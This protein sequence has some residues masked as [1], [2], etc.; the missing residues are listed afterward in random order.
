MG[1]RLVD[2]TGERFGKVTVI[3]R[4]SEYAETPVKW[5]CICECGKE[6]V[7]TSGRL[8][9][10]ATKSCGCSRYEFIS[11]A[12]RIH[13]M[14]K[15]RIHRTWS[16]MIERCTCKTHKQ[17]M[18]YGGRGITVCKDWLDFITFYNWAME[19]GYEHNLT[20]DRI[21]VN[22]NYEPSN[23]RWTDS[24]T[25][26]NNTRKTIKLTIDGVTKSLS[27]W[28]AATGINKIT[29]HGRYR[30]GLRGKDLIEPVNRKCRV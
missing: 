8:K 3:K 13:G 10:G 11:N 14:S 25:Q 19:N 5:L 30:R 1:R 9:R 7:T 20:I 4:A 16:H 24:Y 12:N 22:G 21:D 18:D 6:F 28:S 23:C 26:Q 15:T 27:E 29:L 2:M 17:Y